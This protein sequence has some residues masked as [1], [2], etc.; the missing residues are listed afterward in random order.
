MTPLSVRLRFFLLGAL[1]ALL[2]VT[3]PGTAGAQTSSESGDAFLA[4]VQSRYEALDAFQA[5]FEQTVESDFAQQATDTEGLLIVSGNR[6][7]VET[8]Q[9]TYVT[10]GETSW[11]YSPAD[12]QV[13]VNDASAD[14]VSLS[15]ETF[16]TDYANRF[17]LESRRDV[18]DGGVRY[19]VVDLTP[20]TE[21]S[22]F[23]RVTLRVRLSDLVIT[24]LNVE[25]R[26]GSTVTIRLEDVVLNPRLPAGV[27][28]F[29]PPDDAEVVDLR[30][31]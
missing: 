30:P 23:Q 29:T 2:W 31:S 3:L 26:S 8:D 27:F 14:D 25:D 13:V 21:R 11:I 12:R 7:R 22:S 28:T 19:A 4:R 9:Q 16:F 24:R 1:G 17:T 10:D 5:R 15:P 18:R 6:Y 20:V